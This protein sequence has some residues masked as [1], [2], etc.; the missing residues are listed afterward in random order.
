M[1]HTLT[2]LLWSISSS[3]IAPTITAT[4]V[5]SIMS[6]SANQRVS[7]T[8]TVHR[9]SSVTNTPSSHI[10]PSQISKQGEVNNV[11]YIRTYVCNDHNT[12]V[13]NILPTHIHMYARTLTLVA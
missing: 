4:Q 12:I 10:N 11:V 7:D 9:T 2:G 5:T 3:A 1:L 8:A 6:S 13:Q